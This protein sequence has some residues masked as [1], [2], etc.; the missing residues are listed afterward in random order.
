M[1]T[2][3]IICFGFINIFLG[4]FNSKAAE[5]INIEFEEMSIPIAIDQLSNLSTF[6]EDST[7]LIEWF[8][9]KQI[10]NFLQ[11]SR[12][13]EFPI[14]K[15]EGFSKQILRSWM[16]RKLISQL[17]QTIIIPKDKDGVQIF[18]TI[19]NL[20]D[21]KQEISILDILREIPNKEIKLN[22]NNLILIIS[23]WKKELEQQQALVE[24][25]NLVKI[26]DLKD[27]HYLKKKEIDAFRIYTREIDVSHRDKPIN[28]EIFEPNIIDLK[29]DLIIFMPGLGGDNGNFKWIGK[30]LAN[31]G[32]PVIFID[33]PGSNSEAFNS[34][35]NEN[36]TLPG[37]ADIFLYRIKDLDEVLISFENNSLGFQNK[38]YILMG[39]SLGSLISFLYEGNPPI[40]GLDKRCDNALNDL[41][42]TNLS[43]LLQC[44][45]SEIPIPEFNKSSKL[46]AIVGFSAFG[47]L[48]WPS[49]NSSGIDVPIL[50]IGGT[51]DLITPLISEQFKVFLANENNSLSRFLIIE[52]ASHFSPIR[53]DKNQ[54]KGDVFKINKNF[55]GVYPNDVQNLSIEIIIKFLDTLDRKRGLLIEKRNTNNLNFHVLSKKELIEMQKN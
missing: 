39:H 32:W 49:S 9:T 27:S 19:E 17:S 40:N 54:L 7:E 3:F 21:K 23:S 55:I 42:L 52:G 48:I 29:K 31:R 44:Q 5:R 4:D 2:I 16:G 50:L 24:K 53:F 8:K 47:G 14:F 46:R 25:L 41:G 33:H 6:R 38:S 1:K 12:F 10:K 18:N 13:L 36:D 34:V 43:K 28:I 26:S 45:L 35:I 37:G 22:L 51:Y 20:F 11:L 15:Q 30:A